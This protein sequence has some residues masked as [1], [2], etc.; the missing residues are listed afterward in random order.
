MKTKILL[1]V[2]CHSVIAIRVLSEHELALKQ[3]IRLLKS[4][5]LENGQ[6]IRIIPEQTQKM[7]LWSQNRR[8]KIAN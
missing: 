4:Q 2:T 3:K 1:L 7:L 8:R 5:K 6:A